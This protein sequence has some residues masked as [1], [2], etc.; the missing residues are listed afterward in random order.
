MTQ[1]SLSDTHQNDPQTPQI[2]GLVVAVVFEDLWGG[3]LQ[4]EAGSLQ[5][6]IVWRFE[7]SK[8]KVYDFYL[9]VL[10]LVGEEQVL[11][12]NSTHRQQSFLSAQPHRAT[13]DRTKLDT[14]TCLSRYF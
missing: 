2:A 4:S 12:S 3:V 1:L 6:L 14:G 9:G 13:S 7:A 5:E 10:A 8:S 11:Q